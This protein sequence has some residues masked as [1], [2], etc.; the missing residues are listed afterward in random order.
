MSFSICVLVKNEQQSLKE[1]IQH[2]LSIGFNKIYIF[3]DYGSNT[4][5]SVVSEFGSSV[6]LIRLDEIFESTYAKSLFKF[7]QL[8]RTTRIQDVVFRYFLQNYRDKTDWCAFIDPDEY[9]MPDGYTLEQLASDF[10]DNTGVILMWKVFNANGHINKPTG[11]VVES[12]TQEVS[13]DFEEQFG[14]N[15]KSFVNMKQAVDFEDNHLILDAVDL[16]K[17]P[18]VDLYIHQVVFNKIWINHYFT[19]SWEDWKEK[20]SRGWMV[21]YKKNLNTFFDFNPDLKDLI[22]Y[23]Y[24]RINKTDR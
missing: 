14:C 22:N 9:I 1:W 2:H 15:Y 4:H 3:E 10:K 7:I 19:K 16:N 6:E 13:G 23:D 24:T 11:S 21:N 5:Q 8:Y 12:Y 17:Q 20:V 18:V